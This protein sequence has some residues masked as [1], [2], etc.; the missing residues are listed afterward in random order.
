MITVIPAAAVTAVITAVTA[1]EAR[2]PPDPLPPPGPGRADDLGETRGAERTRA[3]R[4]ADPMRAAGRRVI[5]AGR[6]HLAAEFSRKRD[7][8]QVIWIRCGGNRRGYPGLFDVFGSETAQ[9][10][11]PRDRVQPRIE[12]VRITEPV[13]S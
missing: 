7:R 11:V 3:M 8:G 12:P 6:Q 2:M 9:A 4:H 5:S 13:Q 10:L 1:T